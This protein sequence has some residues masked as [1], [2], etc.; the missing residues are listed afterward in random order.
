MASGLCIGQCRQRSPLLPAGLYLTASWTEEDAACP[1]ESVAASWG[2]KDEAVITFPPTTQDPQ[3]CGL[4]FP[5][6]VALGAP[7]AGLIH[8]QGS[9]LS[10]PQEPQSPGL[11]RPSAWSLR[12]CL[13]Q[14]H[15]TRSGIG[16]EVE[17]RGQRKVLAFPESPSLSQSSAVAQ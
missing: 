15:Q 7:N 17:K 14:K 2:W 11:T 8:R 5:E 10:T 1:P 13:A 16:I 6:S 3:I 9:P 4:L 12:S